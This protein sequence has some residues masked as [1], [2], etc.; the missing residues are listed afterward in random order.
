MKIEAEKMQKSK[1]AEIKV[2][3]SVS[4]LFFANTHF[5]TFQYLIISLCKN[6]YNDDDDG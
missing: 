1:W 3:S 2:H 4:L 6:L 5:I